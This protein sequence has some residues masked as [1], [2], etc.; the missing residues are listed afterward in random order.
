MRQQA[1]SFIART[2]ASTGSWL[3]RFIKDAFEAFLEWRI[4]APGFVRPRRGECGHD[5]LLA[6]GCK[7]RGFCPSCGARR[8]SRTA[9]HLVNHVNLHV[10]VRH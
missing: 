1:A 2:E 4:L 5:K 9:A 6:F 7:L 3:S 10:P 8:M